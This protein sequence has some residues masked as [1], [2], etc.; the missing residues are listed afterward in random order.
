MRIL[1]SLVI[2]GSI[3]ATAAVFGAF[4][5]YTVKDGNGSS[6]TIFAFTC[7]TSKV[8]PASVPIN[9]SGTEIGT[10]ANP[11][12][13]SSP[14]FTA[15]LPSQGGTVIIGGVGIDQT[16]PGTT[17]ATSLKYLNTTAVDA[18]SGN[19]SAGTLRV[20][21]ATDQ[22]ALTNA[23]PV[24]VTQQG[25]AS[26]PKGGIGVVNGGSFYQAVAASATATVL[27]SSTGAAGDYLSHCVI[28]PQ[29]TSPGVVTVFDNT[30]TAANSAILFAGGSS[31]LS[32]LAPIPV[33]VGAV[34][35]NGAWKVTT[36]A[37]VS[38]VCYGKFS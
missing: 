32:N 34:S 14:A 5:D 9:S 27:Q 21:V 12:V 1:H 19:K 36:G 3:A 11:M 22:P 4:A 23:Q 30:N 26:L 16:T 37:N 35:V 20:V 13:V 31:S 33:P 29:S 25:G 15:P 2:A 18:N 24:N 28:Y 6:L 10:G 38:V 8:C 7:F 17:N